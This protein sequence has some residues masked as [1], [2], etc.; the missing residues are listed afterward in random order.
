MELQ[1][2]F[3]QFDPELITHLEAVGQEVEFKEGAMLMRPGQYFKNS[4]IILDGR[5]KLYREGEEGEEFFLYY[6]EK[7]NA[8]ALSMICATKNETS[9]IKAKAMS[10]V[11]ALA[12]PIQYMDGL[13][14]DHREWYYFVLETYR[15]RFSELLEVIDHVVFH[16]MDEKL[17]FYLQRQFEAFGGSKITVTHQ[18][19]AD[20]LNSSR[21]VIS[22]LLKKLEAMKKISISRNEIIRLD[23]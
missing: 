13:M 7:G 22:R 19:I 4:L 17:V 21:E 14:K 16:S 18:E 12:I 11:R 1:Q 15:S 23:L 5:V 3:P 2:L 8:C 10:P 6:L 20:D 9:A